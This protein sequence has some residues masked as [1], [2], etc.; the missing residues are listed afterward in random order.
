MKKQTRRSFIKNSALSAGS[1][2]LL[3]PL[4]ALFAQ[5]LPAKEIPTWRFLVEIAKWCPTVHNLQP[6]QIKAISTTEAE[7]YYN[8]KRLLPVEDPQSIFSTVALGVFIEH[9]SIVAASFGYSITVERLFEPLSTK[10]TTS[11]LFAKLKMVPSSK[12]EQLGLELIKQRRTCRTDYSDLELDDLV[13]E[14]LKQESINHN[15]EFFHSA[16]PELAD[17]MT[18]VNQETLF[19]D[20]EDKATREELDSLFRYNEA[21]AENLKDGLWT[22]CMGFSSKMAKSVFRNHEKWTKGLRKKMLSKHYGS[23]FKNTKNICWMKGKFEDMK[24]W[25]E[26]GRLLARTW[27]TITKRGAYLQPFGSLITNE[28]A[29]AQINSRLDQNAGDQKI[30]MIFRAGYSKQPKRSF[31]LD[32]NELIIS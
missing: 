22:K 5:E 8:P 1:L 14:E 30:W 25:V 24:D 12:E 11:T 29:Y 7:L 26:S 13:I 32:T 10:K 16:D 20:L 19:T 3:S 9:L 27:L 21:D 17:F 28:S 4:K 6:H 2:F 23:T 18:K 31:R 15:Q